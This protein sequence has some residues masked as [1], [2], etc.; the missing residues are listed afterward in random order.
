MGASLS[1]DDL[2]KVINDETI[3]S[4]G[5][6]CGSI[7]LLDLDAAADDPQIVQSV[8]DPYTGELTPLERTSINNNKPIVISDFK[9]ESFFPPHE[10][11]SSAMVV[12]V[13]QHG[14]VLGLIELHGTTTGCL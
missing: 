5:A 7:F 2:L 14:R 1:I 13:S 9:L 6:S 12:P 11:V 3:R 10:G 4:S 8:G